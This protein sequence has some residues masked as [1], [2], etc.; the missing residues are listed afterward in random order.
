MRGYNRF[1]ITPA[2]GVSFGIKSMQVATALALCRF[3][4]RDLFA[5]LSL[6]LSLSSNGK[7]A[8]VDT[9][10]P[11]VPPA[12]TTAS[13]QLQ[14]SSCVVVCRVSPLGIVLLNSFSRRFEFDLHI[15]RRAHARTDGKIGG[16]ELWQLIAIIVGGLVCCISIVVII[17]VLV[18]SVC[19]RSFASF[20]SVRRGCVG[21][22]VI[23]FTLSISPGQGRRRRRGEVDREAPAR[24]DVYVRIRDRR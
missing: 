13:K 23:S 7:V 4:A 8:M 19:T 20:V 21:S 10:V 12:D 22:I 11:Y 9:S 16:L 6:S 18:R 24:A 2:D 5:F 14:G 3:M 15:C 17:V 1:R